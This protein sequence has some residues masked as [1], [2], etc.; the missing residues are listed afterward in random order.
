MPLGQRGHDDGKAATPRESFM[1]SFAAEAQPTTIAT[2]QPY[3]VHP[4]CLTLGAYS[5]GDCRNVWWQ[6]RHLVVMERIAAQPDSL[7][8][9]IGMY[10]AARA[11]STS[12]R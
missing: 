12:L 3:R 9:D 2:L 6:A 10:L 5:K 1:Q 11:A 7:I 4:Q 8:D